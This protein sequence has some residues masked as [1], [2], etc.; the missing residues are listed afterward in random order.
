MIFREL[1]LQNFGP[2]Q[3]RQ[4]LDLSLPPSENSPAIVLFGGM[5][6]GGKTTLLD[7][8]RLALYG[9][10]SQC[11]TRRNLSYGDFLTQ[12][13]NH[14]A[15][16]NTQTAIELAFEHVLDHR[17]K[18][19]RVQRSW[20][21]SPKG[22]RDVLEVLVDD[23]HDEALTKTWNEWIESLLPLGLSSLFL[24]DGEQIKELA[25][26]TA[27]TPS[28]VEAMRSLLGLELADRLSIDLDVLVSRKRKAIANSVELKQLRV[29]EQKLSVA[30]SELEA[31]QAKYQ[32]LADEIMVT[33]ED[34][35]HAQQ[36]FVTQG[37]QIASDRP[38]IEETLG[39]LATQ[40]QDN[41][42]TLKNLAAETL[43][44]G[45]IQPLLEQAKQDIQIEVRRKQVEI[46]RDLLDERDQKL[47]ELLATMKVAKKH[48]TAIQSFLTEEKETLKSEAQISH[49]LQ[50]DQAQFRQL[51]KMLE[52]Q[53][54][55]ALSSAQKLVSEQKTLT[56]SIDA[57]ER[58][59]AA[60]ASPED[61]EKLKTTLL[62]AQEKLEQ[63][64]SEFKLT[65]QQCHRLERAIAS[66]KKELS[67]FSEQ[68]LEQRNTEH[69]IQSADNVQNNLELFRE[70][71]TQLKLSQLETRITECFRYLLHKENLV[72][73][74]VVD[75]NTFGL[76]LFD[77]EGK[78]IPKHRLSAGEKQILAV[79]LLWGLARASGRQIPIV[80][81][82]PLGRLDS[83]HR[84][85]LIE[86]Y[87][88]DASHQVILL[89]TDTEIG[90]LEVEV[91]RD[92]DAI[93]R[94]YLLDYDPKQRCTTVKSG[95]F[96]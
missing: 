41:R 62:Q 24:F 46:A 75:T 88:P 76:N 21:R 59:L 68:T 10:R 32:N 37:G 56:D 7:A 38:Q 42:Q 33:E 87:F 80:I 93:A 45:L 4:T 90:P 83:A 71:L 17:I 57:T 70:K 2:Y 51:E 84:K 1:I 82:T 79:S 95:Y 85:N 16:E 47:L 9:Q 18:T 23:W 28:V 77:N 36:R 54:P 64:Q 50:V 65:E 5:N 53:L 55:Q 60:A 6:G 13:V 58:Q 48:Q 81:D 12:C 39:T 74:V 69:L 78:M 31:E 43:P 22:G 44:V 86:R 67:K 66:I 35:S 52:H 27:P 29:I 8:M 26:Q 63:Q 3:G 49:W 19:I 14:H 20:H 40:Y 73:R 61:Y 92:N 89:S 15:H 30:Q 91:M 25:E 94:E 72:H 34:L 11:S 96:W